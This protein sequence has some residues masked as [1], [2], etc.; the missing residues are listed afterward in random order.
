MIVEQPDSW[1]FPLSNWY[2]RLVEEDPKDKCPLC[3][4]SPMTT[5]CNNGGCDE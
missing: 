1:E 3:E 5:N 4:A 2:S